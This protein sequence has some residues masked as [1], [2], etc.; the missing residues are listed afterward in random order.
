MRKI[1]F[2]NLCFIVAYS[3]MGDN[4]MQ[5]CRNCKRY[6]DIFGW[7]LLLGSFCKSDK[8]MRYLEQI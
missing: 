2:R 8:R 1:H 6:V 4:M 3:N 5:V 7:S